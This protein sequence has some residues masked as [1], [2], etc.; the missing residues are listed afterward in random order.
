MGVNNSRAGM[1]ADDSPTVTFAAQSSRPASEDS[2]IGG[3]TWLPPDARGS[4]VY[5][6]PPSNVWAVAALVLGIVTLALS[7]VPILNQVGILVGFVGVGIGVAAVIVGRRRR[8]RV[9]MGAV[10]LGLSVLG[11]VA[12]FAFTSAYVSAIEGA[13]A[14]VGAPFSR[15]DLG[16]SSSS[17]GPVAFE[18][19]LT[20]PDVD[21]SSAVT[22]TNESGGLEQTM[23]SSLPWRRTVTVDSSDPT[24]YV[25]VGG[26]LPITSSGSSRGTIECTVR[27]DGQVVAHDSQTGQYASVTCQAMA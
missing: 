20:S 14:G 19:E 27:R 7:P 21:S 18:L 23:S 22:W 12:S 10:G 8:V 1:P 13:T 25:S 11:L 15:P 6:P 4:R 16:A 2:P 17:G 9:V 24:A 26:S 3:V 5:P